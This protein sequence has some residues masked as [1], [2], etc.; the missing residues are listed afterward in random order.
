[1]SKLYYVIPTILLQGMGKDIERRCCFRPIFSPRSTV[2]GC[3]SLFLLLFLGETKA[4]QKEVKIAPFNESENELPLA[5]DDEW[6]AH[7]WFLL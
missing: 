1:M 6:N 2:H 7:T 3:H 4:V 5:Y